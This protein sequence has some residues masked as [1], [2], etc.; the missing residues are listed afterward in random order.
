VLVNIAAPADVTATSTNPS[1]ANQPPGQNPAPIS[2]RKQAI[3][4]T[5][6]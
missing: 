4:G 2:D 1:G 5:E 3:A 6:I